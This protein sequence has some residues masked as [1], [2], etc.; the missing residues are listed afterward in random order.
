MSVFLKN[1]VLPFLKSYWRELL[2][3]AALSAIFVKKHIDYLRLEQAYS[4]SQESLKDQLLTLKDL[5]AEELERRDEALSNYRDTIAALR[6]DY[7]KGLDRLERD[8]NQQ[9]EDIVTEIIEREQL[10][11]NRDELAE[12]IK[13][14]LGFVYVR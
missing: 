13:N 5:H 2:I 6:D 14:E 10:T 9:Q 7:E 3:V 8:S 1:I 11:E 12:K 4:V